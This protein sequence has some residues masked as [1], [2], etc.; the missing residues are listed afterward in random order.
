MDET[1]AYYTEWSRSERKTPVQYIKHIYGF[2]KDGN[3]DLI[4]KIAKRHRLK[5]KEKQPF[6][7]WEKARVG[8]FEIIGLKH[9]YYHMWNRWPAQVRCVKQGTQSRC[10]GTSQRDGMGREVSGGFG[11]QGHRYTHSWFMSMYGKS[12]HNIVK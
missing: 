4:C 3:D 12:H 2:S 1:G 10:T 6:G 5:N 11:T 9:V 8:W 7:L